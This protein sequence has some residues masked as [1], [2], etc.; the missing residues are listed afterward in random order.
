MTKVISLADDAYDML[1]AAKG[2]NDSF[3]DVVRNTFGRKKDIMKAFG[4]AKDNPDFIRAMKSVIKE[5]KNV[6]TRE[7]RF[8]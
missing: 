7:L 6:K 2:E 4:I 1:K 8:D 5:R 3:S